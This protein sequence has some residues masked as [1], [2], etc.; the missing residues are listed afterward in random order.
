MR[1][2]SH[3]LDVDGVSVD[4]EKVRAISSFQKED[5]MEADGCTPS[6]HK[7]RSFVGMV[8]FYQHFIPGCSRITKLLF[9]LTAGQRSS[10]PRESRHLP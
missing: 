3:V 5:L 10:W 2:L 1:F 6:Q 7:V 4:Q 8:M 9:A